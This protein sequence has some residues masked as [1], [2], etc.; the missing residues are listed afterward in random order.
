MFIIKCLF[1]NLVFLTDTFL[2]ITDRS[3]GKKSTILGRR[4]HGEAGPL[5]GISEKY[6]FSSVFYST[7]FTLQ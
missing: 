3:G 7:Y 1:K 4:L 5:L 6:T 2:F